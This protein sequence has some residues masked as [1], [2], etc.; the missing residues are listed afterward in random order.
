MATQKR[1][2]SSKRRRY[3]RKLQF[4]GDVTQQEIDAMI[5]K[6]EGVTAEIVELKRRIVE[7]NGIPLEE[8]LS[9]KATEDVVEPLALELPP[10]YDNESELA[11]PKELGNGTDTTYSTVEPEDEWTNGWEN[12]QATALAPVPATPMPVTEVEPVAADTPLLTQEPEPTQQPIIDNIPPATP[13]EASLENPDYDGTPLP[14]DVMF[15]DKY[16]T[17]RALKQRFII[18]KRE[19][20]SMLRQKN[21]TPDQIKDTRL[22]YVALNKL[23]K[24]LAAATSADQYITMLRDETNK[25]TLG[26]LK[27]GRKTRKC[28]SGM[29]R[30]T[31]GKR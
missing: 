6:V 24:Q 7:E 28:K 21:K 4:G 8:P 22:K 10:A 16:P 27:G 5:T 17:I 3:R 31:R 13:V 9:E 12:S 11:T 30:Q 14:S 1:K 25:N 26:L 15:S 20:D 19:F 2:A 29:R 23:N 18:K